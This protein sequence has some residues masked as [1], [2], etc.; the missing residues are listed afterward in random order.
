MFTAAW[1]A[2]AARGKQPKCPWLGPSEINMA[3]PHV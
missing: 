1:L 3:H 2:V